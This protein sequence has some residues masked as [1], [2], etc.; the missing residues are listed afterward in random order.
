MATC[1]GTAQCHTQGVYWENEIQD[2]PRE[3]DIF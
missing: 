2:D 1:F 3:P